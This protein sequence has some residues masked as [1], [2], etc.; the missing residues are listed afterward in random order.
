LSLAEALGPAIQL[1]DG[2][3]WYDFLTFYLRPELERMAAYPSGARVYL[4]GP[5]GSIPPVGSMFRQPDLARTLRAL[6]EAEQQNASQGRRA[7]IN[8]AR[9]RFY[10]GD[11]GRRIVKAVRDSAGLMTEADLAGYRGRVEQPTRVAFSTRHGKF[12]IIKTGF[13]GQGP[14]LLQTL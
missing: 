13:W 6:V 8:A 2:F 10:R 14:V 7:A 12:E 11:I 9:D 4:Q 3:P 5:G 1:A